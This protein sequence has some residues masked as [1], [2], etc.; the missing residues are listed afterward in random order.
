MRQR[1][2]YAVAGDGSPIYYHM[3]GDRRPGGLDII[4]SLACDTL[5]VTAERIVPNALV[6]RQPELN[7]IPSFRTTCVVEA[8][9]GAHPCSMPG[10]YDLD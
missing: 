1:E 2:G 7:E 5:V 4:L 10:H 6:R 8:P 3:H 9:F